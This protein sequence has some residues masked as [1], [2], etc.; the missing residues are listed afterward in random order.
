MKSHSQNTAQMQKIKKTASKFCKNAKSKRQNTLYGCNSTKMV[1][2]G[3]GE[4]DMERNNGRNATWSK[5]IYPAKYE[6]ESKTS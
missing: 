1:Y 2:N 5:P 6:N 4:R 3:K